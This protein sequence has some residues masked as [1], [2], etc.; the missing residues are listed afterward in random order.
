[1]FFH[2]VPTPPVGPPSIGPSAADR[3]R[4]RWKTSRRARGRAEP[5]VKSREENKR[6]RKT[7][8]KTFP[9]V[10][11]TSVDRT[12]IVRGVRVETTMA[13]RN[14]GATERKGAKK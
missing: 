12:R 4:H 7:K 8:D 13:G 5:N 10:M 3:R 11:H 9:L 14:G 2:A 6:E 1:M